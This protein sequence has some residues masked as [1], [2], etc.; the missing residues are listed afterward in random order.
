[1]SKK[2]HFFKKTASKKRTY[3]RSSATRKQ[4][5][6]IIRTN[7]KVQ[8]SKALGFFKKLKGLKYGTS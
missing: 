6:G 4:E 3:K 1:M 5:I 2:G 8:M 7:V